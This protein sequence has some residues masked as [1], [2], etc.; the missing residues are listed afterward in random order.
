MAHLFHPPAIVSPAAD[1]RLLAQRINAAHH[2]GEEF[3]RR[4]IEDFRSAGEELLKA[5][6]MIGHGG[7]SS[8]VERNVDFSYRTAARYMRLALMWSK[9][10]TVTHLT[11]AMRVLSAEA[12]VLA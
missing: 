2:S 1:L 3:T 4:G 9:C 6:R 8:W 5:K 10:D 11:A 7:F 12:E